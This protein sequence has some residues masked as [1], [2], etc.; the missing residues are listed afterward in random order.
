MG[1][2]GGKAYRASLCTK[3]ISLIYNTK[4]YNF[5]KSTPG[6]K[7]VGGRSGEFAVCI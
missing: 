6:E 4:E 7:A 3:E 1:N 5:A 2:R